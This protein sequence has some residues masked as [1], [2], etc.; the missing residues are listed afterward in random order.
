MQKTD[1]NTTILIFN[2]SIEE[3]EVKYSLFLAVLS[4]N[5]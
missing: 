3:I 5:S 2:L 4:H 1:K